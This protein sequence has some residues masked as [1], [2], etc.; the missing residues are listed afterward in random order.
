MPVDVLVPPLGT[1]VDVLTLVAWYKQEGDL[2]QK[3]EP[4]FSVETDKATLDVESPASGI[5]R[6]V[7]AKAGDAITALHRIAVI[8][9]PGEAFDA[10]AGETAEGAPEA[11]SP[12]AMR[13]P[14]PVRACNRVFISPRARR[15]AEMQG[16]VWQ[17]LTGTGPEGA[18]VERDIVQAMTARTRSA[19]PVAQKIAAQEGVDWTQIAGSGAGGKVVREDIQQVLQ[20][21]GGAENT[22]SETIPLAGARATIARRMRESAATTAPVTLTSETDAAELVALRARLQED[23]VSVSY[24]DLLIAILARALRDHPRLNASLQGE[25]IQVWQ[26]IHIGLAVDAEQGLRVPVVRDADTKRLT[27]ISRETQSLVERARLGKLPPEAMLGATC[28]LTNLGMFGIDAFTPVIPLPE[29]AILGVGRIKPQPSV[30]GDQI[31]VRQKMWLS[32]TFDHRLVDGGPA[33]RF[34]QRVAQ[35]IEKPHLLHA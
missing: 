15:A 35:L 17:N 3:D 23:G 13:S 31:L 28:T 11:Q 10:P 2:V 12:A 19:S 6:G 18:I 1:T 33:A 26:R 30:V 8:A 4:L 29:C 14:Q 21:R 5:L 27:E 9:A 20:Q 34:L 24:T 32:L 25:T 7:D 16:I 22:P